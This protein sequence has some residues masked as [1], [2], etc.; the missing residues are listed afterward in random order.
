MSS[1][2]TVERAVQF[3]TMSLLALAALALAGCESDAESFCASLCECGECGDEQ[4]CVDT[5]ETF[6]DAA[7]ELG[8][9]RQGEEYV[10][11]LSEQFECTEGRAVVS[12]ETAQAGAE[13]C[14]GIRIVLL[15]DPPSP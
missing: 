1:K 14:M 6:L 5:L 7:D 11:C 15:A 8:C 13:E 10:E 2:T 4:Q 9:E 12:C 3:G